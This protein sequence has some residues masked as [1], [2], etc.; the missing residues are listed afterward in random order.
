MRLLGALI[1][2]ILVVTAL[3]DACPKDSLCYEQLKHQRT[4]EVMKTIL[5]QLGMDAP[6]NVPKEKMPSAEMRREMRRLAEE[7]MDELELKLM[8]E[9]ET[10]MVIASDPS[11][12]EDESSLISYFDFGTHDFEA[13]QVKEAKLSFYA[14]LDIPTYNQEVNIQVYEKSTDGKLG[15]L[16]VTAFHTISNS[17]RLTVQIPPKDVGRLIEAE[18]NTKG[19]FVSA[20]F[21]GKNIAIHPQETMNDYENMILQITMAPTQSMS[22]SSRKRRDTSA[23]VCHADSKEKTCCL[24][25]LEIDFEKIGWD[26]IVAPDRYNAY[27]CRGTCDYG[28][29]KPAFLD[30]GHHK[31]VAALQKGGEKNDILSRS[32]VCCHPTQYDYIRLLY[33]NRDGRVSIANVNGMVARKCA[34]S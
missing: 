10:V 19:I 3:S 34:C 28:E 12:G 32:S 24:Y 23:A 20:K 15:D 29:N 11:N 17:Q 16:I 8:A 2:A 25:D 4:A 7:N 30:Y 14:Y 31:V 1:G 18:P 6:P 13:A 9:E 33:V 21:S 22:S 5:T 26:W 27:V